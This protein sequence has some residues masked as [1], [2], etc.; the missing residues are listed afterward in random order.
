MKNKE[1]VISVVIPV[2]N[3]SKTIKA[4]LNSVYQQNINYPIEVIIIDDASRDKDD[5]LNAV[6]SIK[7]EHIGREVYV[8]IIHHEVNRHGSAARNTGIKAANGKYIA[9]LDSDDV[10]PQEK[11]ITCF[12]IAEHSDVNTILYSKVV[13][14]GSIYPKS[15][16]GINEEVD[17]YLILRKGAMQTSTLFM[18]TKFA[19]RVL[20][21][22]EL[23]RFQDYD[24]I[25][26][27]Q[28]LHNARFKFVD[29]ITV[30]MTDDNLGSRISN[31]I[32]YR[33]AVIWLNKIE[34]LLSKRA[35]SVFAFNRIANYCALSGHKLK[36]VKIFIHYKSYQHFKYLNKKVFLKILIP[37]LL[38]DFLKKVK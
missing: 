5:L 36:A 31:S 8:H 24:F 19:K 14:R 38:F 28:K 17:E 32:D 34:N 35:R 29:N 15:P 37:S 25:I 18:T 10:W 33:P 2:Y 26:R 21:D 13:D 27:A 30:C 23:K 6:N 1:V 12:E 20:F 4:T 16:I 22:E 3:S 7:S 9:F 11:L